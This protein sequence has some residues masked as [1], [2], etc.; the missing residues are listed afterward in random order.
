MIKGAYASLLYVSQALLMAWMP[1]LTLRRNFGQINRP[2]PLNPLVAVTQP[3]TTP[4][5][6]A[7]GPNETTPE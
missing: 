1:P 2:K 5:G 4:D 6:P 7:T 3:R